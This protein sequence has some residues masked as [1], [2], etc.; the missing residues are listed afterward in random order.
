MAC[1]NGKYYPFLSNPILEFTCF[2]SGILTVYIMPIPTVCRKVAPARQQKK[3]CNCHQVIISPHQTNNSQFFIEIN[4]ARY[5]T[6]ESSLLITDTNSALIYVQVNPRTLDFLY[7]NIYEM[8]RNQKQP[9]KIF[10]LKM[11]CWISSK[12]PNDLGWRASLI[13]INCESSVHMRLGRQLMRFWIVYNMN[14]QEK[15][16]KLEWDRTCCSK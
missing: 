9:A 15:L 16:M 5:F 3:T 2:L 11:S 7:W 4:L 1:P 12:P 13:Q 14:A 10:Q 6:Q 8:S